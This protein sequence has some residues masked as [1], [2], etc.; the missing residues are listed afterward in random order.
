VGTVA[1]H[2]CHQPPPLQRRQSRSMVMTAM[3]INDAAVRQQGQREGHNNQ[4]KA[5]A[6]KM[7]FNCSG[8]GNEDGVQLQ[9]RWVTKIRKQQ[10]T[11]EQ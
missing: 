2:H 3:D 1:S 5:T 8:D 7:A 11:N 10:S 9:R 6:V 4:I